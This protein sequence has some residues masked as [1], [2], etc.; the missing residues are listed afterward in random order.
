MKTG[1]LI[2][3]VGID[4]CGKSTQIL[5]MV[6]NLEGN[7]YQCKI[8]RCGAHV[9][10]FTLP[11]YCI[12]KIIGIVPNYQRSNRYIHT[13]KYP[14]VYKNKII[15]VLWPWTVFFDSCIL[16]LIRIKIPLMTHDYVFSDRYIYDVIVEIMVSTRNYNFCETIIG[17]LFFRLSN[18][19]RIYY[20][21]INE[22]EAFK[23][24][25]DIP[26]I[27]FLRIRKEMYNIVMSKLLIISINAND[28]LD[29]VHE[30]IKK[31]LNV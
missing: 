10:F 12:S 18:A 16:E 31:S 2:C 26:D 24:K 30:N 21:E 17:E 27:E 1:N 3:F 6:N 28:P 15:S 19:S 4:G 20:L 11:L 9:R 23:R 25:N 5:K 29:V 13:S 22:I 8:V 14:D 7:H